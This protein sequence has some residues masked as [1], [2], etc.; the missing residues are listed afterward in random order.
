MEIG[1]RP[2]KPFEWPD[3]ARLGVTVT[4][5]FEAYVYHGHY[6]S[7]KPGKVDHLSMSFAEYAYKVGA[8]RIMDVLEKNGLRGC[9]DCNGLAAKKYP[10]IVA[11]MAKRGHE[12]AGHGWANDMYPSD[13]DF[14]GEERDLKNTMAAIAA[15]TGKPPV[16]WVG[17]GSTHTAKTLDHMI[18]QGFLWNGDDVSHDV[19]FVRVHKG[20]P[21]VILPRTNLATN[22]LRMFLRPA[23][24]PLAYWDGFKEAFDFCYEEG[25]A[26]RPLWIDLILHCDIGARP[27][28]IGVFQRC[29]DYCFKHKKV[30]YGR[31]RDL[32]Q[33]TLEHYGD[34]ALAAEK[35]GGKGKAKKGK[36]KQK[37]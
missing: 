32:A 8:W 23:N 21:L 20:K 30:W 25:K 3:K 12:T 31:R 13:D 5:G 14:A 2:P 36:S 9:F 4:I 29:L 15:A 6:G 35:K 16:G 1:L 34:E 27:A 24:S 11:D 19:P 7:H 28:L 26:G 18:E 33:W 17:P 10:A 37:R 22:D